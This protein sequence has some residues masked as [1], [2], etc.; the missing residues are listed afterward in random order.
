MKK[1]KVSVIGSGGRELSL[2]EKI[3]QSPLVKKIYVIPGNSGVDGLIK[4]ERVNIKADQI[5]QLYNFALDNKIDLTVVGPEIPLING[6][7]NLFAEKG[8]A[9]FG[10]GKDGANLEGSK[11]DAKNFMKK[12]NIPTAPFLATD[13]F[14]EAKNYIETMKKI[15]NGFVVKA[16]GPYAGKGVKVCD[17][18]EEAINIANEMLV[19][20]KYGEA[21]RRIVIEDRLDGPNSREISFIVITD[22]ETILSLESSKDHKQV[23]DGD[24]GENTGGM[25]AISPAPAMTTEIYDK[26]MKKICG[27]LLEGLKKENIT[28]KGFLYIGLIIVDGEPYVLEFNC[29]GGDPETQVILPRM[30][31]D[32]VE[33]MLA[34]LNGSLSKIKLDW[35]P[36]PCTYVVL[37]AKGYPGNY[38][39][40]IKLFGLEDLEKRKDLF[41]IHA[42]TEVVGI[43]GGAHRYH[44]STGGRIVGI[45]A[46]GENARDIIYKE[47]RS[48]EVQ[49][50]E[51]H[52]RHDIGL[53]N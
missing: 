17:S 52:Y 40:R 51:I 30:K 19:Q 3:S 13:N 16:Y 32:L 33:I 18:P 22:G 8:L 45:G 50:G 53:R 37:A 24:E 15:N 11:V 20:G 36:R 26:I 2:A 38:P 6:I 34:T 39:K 48:I 4:A 7:G 46:L 44:E 5:D 49:G 43:C 41:V 27:P 28:Y 35:D 14:E 9:L 21:G 23:N 25:G 31:T 29:R 10:P 47:I 1:I 12:Y 42:G